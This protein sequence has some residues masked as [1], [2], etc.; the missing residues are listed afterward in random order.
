VRI[1]ANA[2]ALGLA[3]LSAGCITVERER[4]PRAEPDRV[5]GIRTECTVADGGKQFRA[6][7]PDRCDSWEASFRGQNASA[8]YLEHHAKVLT[9]RTW[10]GNT[11]TIEVSPSTEVNL[12]D[13]WP[14]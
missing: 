12:G 5:V 14:P 13:S 11:Y 8:A 10:S 9:I 2:L 6:T 1:T 4:E 7:D 3:L